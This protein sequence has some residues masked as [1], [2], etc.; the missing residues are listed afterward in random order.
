MREERTCERREEMGEE[1][2]NGRGDRKWGEERGDGRRQR[3]E[4][5]SE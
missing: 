5:M 2:G 3:N 4:R 1:T